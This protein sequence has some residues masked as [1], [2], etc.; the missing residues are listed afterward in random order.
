VVIVATAA[1]DLPQIL[2]RNVREARIRRGMSQEAL[3]LEA[4]MKRSYVSDLE[5][6]TRNPSV[7][8]IERLA[9]ALDVR[10]RD[11]LDAATGTS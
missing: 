11:L 8:A 7:K 2:G 5:R 9:I 6:G 3:G 1:M 10:P 4:G